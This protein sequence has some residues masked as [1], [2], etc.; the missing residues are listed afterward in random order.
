MAIKEKRVVQSV[1]VCDYCESDIQGNTG[2]HIEGKASGYMKRDGLQFDLCENCS[3]QIGLKRRGR[4]PTFEGEQARPKKAKNDAEAE[5][6][7]KRRPGRPKKV[8]VAGAED[9]PKQEILAP[10][11]ITADDWN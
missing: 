8:A 4:R 3:N 5:A 11:E 7:P 1:L 9:Q 2:T 10:V 6:K